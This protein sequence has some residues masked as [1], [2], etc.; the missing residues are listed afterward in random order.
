MDSDKEEEKD[1]AA[2]AKPIQHMT[3]EFNN[4]Q[5]EKDFF[6]YA[7]GEIKPTQK[8]KEIS[9]MIRNHKRAKER[10]R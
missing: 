6:K 3:I 2:A 1:M 7:F 8:I 10:K 5:E 4:P 9:N